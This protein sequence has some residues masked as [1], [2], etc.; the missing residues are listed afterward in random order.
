M[1]T[2]ELFKSEFLKIERY[3]K[4]INANGFSIKT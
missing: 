3:L 4:D 2:L 1:N